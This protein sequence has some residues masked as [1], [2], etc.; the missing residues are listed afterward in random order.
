LGMNRILL[1]IVGVLAALWTSLFA[2]WNSLSADSGD[3]R[4]ERFPAEDQ[5]LFA[6]GDRVLLAAGDIVECT[7]DNSA[8]TANIVQRFPKATVATLGDNAYPD[9]S[10]ED[11]ECYD[12]TWGSFKDRTRPAVG[13]HEYRTRGAAGYFDYFGARAGDRKKG[14]Y[15]YRLGSWRVIVLNSMCKEI[16][17][18]GPRSKQYRWLKRTLAKSTER[19]TLA[20]MHHPWMSSG[21]HGSTRKI[22][23]MVE[24]LYRYRAEVIL[25][26]HDHHYERFAPQRPNGRRDIQRGIRQF[27]VGTGGRKPRPLRKPLKNSQVSNDTDLGVLK[28][29]LRR[30]SYTWRFISVN[31][32]FTDKGRDFCH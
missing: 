14:Y 25:S 1:S 12:R 15:T 30:G 28:L 10:A 4:K 13:N 17:R 18:C 11:F 2:S 7:N 32:E 27:V 20:Y 24:L 23:Y 9:G 16:R 3:N 29:V 31:R 8:T 22:K 26:G 6:A 5:V 19:C 21:L